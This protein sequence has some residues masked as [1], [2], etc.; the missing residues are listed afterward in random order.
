MWTTSS[1]LAE[2]LAILAVIGAGAG[3]QTAAPE[4]PAPARP[5][6][7]GPRTVEHGQLKRPI[8]LR[9]VTVARLD[10]RRMSTLGDFGKTAR[11]PIVIEVHLA[12]PVDM[13][14]RDS[15][16]VII[17]NDV[18]LPDTWVYAEHPDVLVAY[19]PDRSKIRERNTVKAAWLGNEEWTTSRTALT[20]NANDIKGP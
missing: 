16:P 13:T 1:S 8:N 19:L 10:A 20:F 3:C 18:T 11:D 12:E 5:V 7:Q 2:R 17:L 15:S 9:S 14:P 6:V 4:S